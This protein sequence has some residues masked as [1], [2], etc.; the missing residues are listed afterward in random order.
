M[1]SI[2]MPCTKDIRNQGLVYSQPTGDYE[3]VNDSQRGKV[4]HTTSATDID[5]LIKSTEGWDMST[6]SCGFGAWL[7][8]NLNE[9][10]FASAYTYTSSVSGIRNVVLGYNSYG[11]F[12]F[13][14]S[15]NNI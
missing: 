3:V 13:D 2:W 5:T 6:G 15:S 10:K 4:V 7:K 8:F 9:M 14:F 12:S 11:G 1:L